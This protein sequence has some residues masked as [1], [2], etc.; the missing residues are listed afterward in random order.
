MNYFLILTAAF[1]LRLLLNILLIWVNINKQFQ[2]LTL[3]LL[4]SPVAHFLG[5][6]MSE[7]SF[8]LHHRMLGLN[9]TKLPFKK[10]CSSCQGSFSL[11]LFLQSARLP[12]DLGRNG[13]VCFSIIDV[14]FHACH[15]CPSLAASLSPNDPEW[16]APLGSWWPVRQIGSVRQV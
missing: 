4:P 2:H 16:K 15:T 7:T 12:W 13:R 9:A 3:T 1:M 5:K 11:S 6:G 14:H 10:K 8:L